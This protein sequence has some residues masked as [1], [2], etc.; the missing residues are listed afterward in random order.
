[1]KMN[2]IIIMMMG[3]ALCS[4]LGMYACFGVAYTNRPLIMG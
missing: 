3:A 2:T 4:A 1:M